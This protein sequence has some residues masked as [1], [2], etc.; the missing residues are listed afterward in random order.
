VTGVVA[1]PQHRQV[2]VC[3][4]AHTPGG[5]GWCCDIADCSPCCPECPTCVL[6]ISSEAASPGWRVRAAADRRR[7]QSE[8]WAD[9]RAL[10]SIA[11]AL[12]WFDRSDWARTIVH[13]PVP[14]IVS[15]SRAVA[16]AFRDEVFG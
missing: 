14:Q 9:R 8:F 6:C 3:C 4:A 13:P 2:R 7:W 15:T 1:V 11:A 12:W 5:L 16:R 10:A